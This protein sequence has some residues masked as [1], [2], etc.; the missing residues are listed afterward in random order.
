MFVENDVDNAQALNAVLH[1][2]CTSFHIIH[3]ITN[4]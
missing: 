1:F 3:V 4:N 2:I